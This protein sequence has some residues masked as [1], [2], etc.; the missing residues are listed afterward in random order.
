MNETRRFFSLAAGALG[1]A[2][3]FLPFASA[4]SPLE[5]LQLS[6]E[7]EGDGFFLFSISAPTLLAVPIALWQVRRLFVPA[8]SQR[9]IALAYGFG[10]L[11]MLPVMSTSVLVLTEGGDAATP[12]SIAALALEWCAVLANLALLARNRK[13]RTHPTGIAAEAYLLLG[14]V[15]NALYALVFFSYWSFIFEPGWAWNIGAYVVLATCLA[16]IAQTVSLLRAPP[17]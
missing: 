7:L 9:E 5:A 4:V 6:F 14:Y 1:I 12:T 15:P 17:A 3:L 8:P 16:C 2:A 13:V 10:T 11:A